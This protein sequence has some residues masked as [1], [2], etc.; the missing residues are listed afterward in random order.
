MNLSTM[1]MP[2][3]LRMR[4]L[5]PL[6]EADGS[7][8]LI[9][10]LERAAVLD[11]PEEL[12]LHVGTTLDTGDLDESLLGWMLSEDLLTAEGWS[13]YEEAEAPLIMASW[14]SLGLVFRRGGEVH[15]RIDNP[16][17]DSALSALD[18]IFKQ[19]LGAV[20]VI[21]RLS[22]GGAFPATQMLE[23]IVVEA[24]R[25]AA[26]NRQEVRYELSL[27][28]WVVTP[29]VAAFLAD[30]PFH[31][32]LHCGSF[33]GVADVEGVAGVET[34]APVEGAH[35][36]KLAE[37]GVR[38][39]LGQTE[40]LT[41]QCVLDGP[42]R[43]RDLWAWAKEL[44]VRFLDPVR[45]ETNDPLSPYLCQYRDDLLAIS[46]EICARLGNPRAPLPQQPPVD[47]QPLSRVVTT[48][49]RTETLARSPRLS[50]ETS[51]GTGDV[52]PSPED[53]STLLSH[54]W[55]TL[56][57]RGQEDREAAGVPDGDRGDIAEIPCTGCWARYL[58]SHSA[59]PASPVNA[60][61]DHRD[62]DEARCAF[63]RTEVEAGLRFYHRLAHADP[64]QAM[65]LFDEPEVP[66][67]PFDRHYQMSQP[68]MPF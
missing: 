55:N 9:Y 40:R 11:V 33:V 46:E 26:L 14:W 32:R 27:D 50:T 7:C 31:V 25:R 16:A 30:Y 44:G 24:N 4:S 22:W 61:A 12:Q 67:D 37:K 15:A 51:W 53:E 64:I 42:S 41:V 18:F 62:P 2:G 34:G 48:L 19:S 49:M 52:Y 63:W 59:L 20:R 5:Y 21:L 36:W 39:L 58:C 28:A 66:V 54:M 56:E 3:A 43:L 47:C 57:Q 13:G 17:L 8:T 68:K 1:A 29:A 6:L 65:R 60:S 35:A 10:D 23:G 45:L 38:L